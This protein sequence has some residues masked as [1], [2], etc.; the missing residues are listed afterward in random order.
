LA[1]H[2]AGTNSGHIIINL[3]IP[4]GI[5]K[6][7]TTFEGEPKAVLHL[8]ESINSLLLDPVPI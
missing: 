5:P 7:V 3:C 2:L 8:G 4:P 1:Q 6:M